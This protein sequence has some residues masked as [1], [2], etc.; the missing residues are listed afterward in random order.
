M[1]TTT[2]TSTR[3]IFTQSEYPVIHLRETLLSCTHRHPTRPHSTTY[4]PIHPPPT[5]QHHTSIIC[6]DI[7]SVT[8]YCRYIKF[9]LTASQSSSARQFAMQPTIGRSSVANQHL[10]QHRQTNSINLST[11]DGV[12]FLRLIMLLLFLLL[13]MLVLIFVFAFERHHRDRETYISIL[14]ECWKF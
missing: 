5:T 6:L 3:K 7:D 12:L 14:I 10:W 9:K 2:T 1:S 8:D 13:L 4:M 11:V